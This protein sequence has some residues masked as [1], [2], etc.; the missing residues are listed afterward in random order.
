MFLKRS[1]ALL[2]MALALG[3]PSDANRKPPRCRCRLGCVLR[4]SASDNRADREA[5][6]GALHLRAVRQR[7]HLNFPPCR[8]DATLVDTWLVLLRLGLRRSDLEHAEGTCGE[9]D[10]VAAAAD[11]RTAI[12]GD[13]TDLLSKR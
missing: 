5:A 6:P 11:M 13:E 9:L 4:E 8:G 1:Q 3:E 2:G 12:R 10:I 7:H